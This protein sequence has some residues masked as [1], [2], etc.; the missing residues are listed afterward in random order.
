M[1]SRHFGMVFL[2]LFIAVGCGGDSGEAPPPTGTLELTILDSDTGNG[3]AEARVIVFDGFTGESID[4]LSTDGNGEVSKVFDVGSLLLDVSSQDYSASPPPG[5]P[6]LPVQIVSNETTAITVSLNR[7]PAADRGIISG[8]VTNDQGQSAAGALIV[9][10]AADGTVSSTTTHSDGSY[11]LHNVASGSATVET[12]LGGLNFAPITAVNVSPNSTKRQDIQ[13]AGTATG[14]ISGHVSFTAVSGDIIDITL[15]HPATRDTLPNLSVL[16]DSGGSYTMNGVPYGEFEIVASLDNDD[17]VLDPDLSV[18]QGVPVVTI[19]EVAPTISNRD[20]KVTG[21][22]G[23]S[24]PADSIDGSVPGLGDTPTFTWVKS[25]SFASASYY[26]VEVVDESGATIW[27][28]FDLPVNNFAPIVTVPQGNEPSALYNFDGT[29]LL[30]VLSPN[31]HYQLRIYA[32][33]ED[34]SDPKGY[35]LLSASETLDGIFK[36]AAP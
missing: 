25:S 19:T 1:R 32:A 18:T 5:I 23:L 12:F 29:A 20:F 7:L 36:V 4:L 28:G 13:A 11:V 10:T 33:V 3:I 2:T 17:F 31:R 35:R 34:V 9:V 22:I 15:L 14:E 26:V 16:T 27:G 8:S 6:P 21:S 24:N 30:S